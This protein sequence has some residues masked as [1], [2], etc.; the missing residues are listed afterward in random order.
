M[1]WLKIAIVTLVLLVACVALD[2]A[3]LVW[4]PKAC[5]AKRQ[6]ATTSKSPE[7][8]ATLVEEEEQDREDDAP[9][10]PRKRVA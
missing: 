6:G 9:S 10:A 4:L 3:A 5:R 8:V 2:H 7:V 1:D